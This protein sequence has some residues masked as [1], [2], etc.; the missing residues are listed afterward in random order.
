MID[1]NTHILPMIDFGSKTLDQ[2]L[3]LAKLFIK[4]GITDVVASPTYAEPISILAYTKQLNVEL[5]NRALDLTVHPAQRIDIAN[6]NYR[7]LLDG[8]VI[9]LGQNIKTP[10]I[11]IQN[12]ANVLHYLDTFKEMSLFGVHPI[13]EHPERNISIQNNPDILI[14]LII[15]GA[16]I[17][18][19]SA[20]L[21]GDYGKSVQKLAKEM[22]KY[23]YV[24][25]LASE[26]RDLNHSN[27]S[28]KAALKVAKKVS[29]KDGV[30]NLSR[31]SSKI[32][33]GYIPSIVIPQQIPDK[34]I[35]RY[36]MM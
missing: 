33:N 3:Q 27:G 17:Q 14:E 7:D 15:M 5:R 13:I 28:L 11:S 10:L 22:L 8:K 24:H 32:L 1:L 4:D 18:V 30:E 26:T 34:A 20:S 36:A 35:Q 21:I 16:I 12:N 6:Y 25:V 9:G 2:S 23:G 29:G 19:Q 31:N